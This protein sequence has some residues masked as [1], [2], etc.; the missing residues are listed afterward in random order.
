MSALQAGLRTADLARGSERTI[1]T[2]TM[3]EKIAEYVRAAAAVK[4]SVAS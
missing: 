2:D 4:A 3:G 1:T